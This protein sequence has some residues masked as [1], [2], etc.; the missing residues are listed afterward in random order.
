MLEHRVKFWTT[1]MQGT[2]IWA[3]KKVGMP[4]CQCSFLQ[5]PPCIRA[6]LGRALETVDELPGTLYVVDLGVCY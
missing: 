1:K 4:N 3:S 2:A 5:L 6:E